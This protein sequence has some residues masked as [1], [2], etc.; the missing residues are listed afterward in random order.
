MK[1]ALELRTACVLLGTTLLVLGCGDGGNPTLA[2]AAPVSD[3]ADNGRSLPPVVDADVSSG[4]SEAGARKDVADATGSAADGLAAV[5][6]ALPPRITVTILTPTQGPAADGGIAAPTVVVKTDRLAPD[7][8]V[9]IESFSSDGVKDVLASVKASLVGVQSKGVAVS[10]TLNQTQYTIVPESNTKVY[11]FSDT[12][13]DL[14]TLSSDFYDLQITALTVGGTSATATTRI[15]VDGGPTITFLQPQAGAY[16][17]GSIVVTATVTDSQSGLAS[18]A[19]SIGQYQLAPGAITSKDSQYTA[20]LDFGSYNPP[21]DGDQIIS[22]EAKNR[23]GTASL[24]TRKF[25]IDNVGPV[26]SATK[27]ATGDLIGKIITIEAKVADQAGVMTSSVVAVVAHGDTHFEVNLV[28]GSDGTYRQIFDTTQLPTYAIFPSISFRAQD[29]LGNQSSVG[30]LVSLDNTPP[31]MDLDPPDQFQL[32]R[33]NGE[34][35]WPFDPVGPDAIDDGSVVTQLFDLRARIE[36][37]GNDALTGTPDFVPISAVDPASV[38]VLILDDTSLPLVV[39]TSDP[40]DGICDDINPQ[41]VPSIDPQTSKDAQLLDM[42]PLP[43]YT[44]AGNFTYRPGSL[45]SGSD[46]SEPQPFCATA[47]SSLKNES[48]TYVLG[49]SSSLLSAIWTV[50]PIVADGLQCAGRQF[51]ASNNLHDGWACVAV[52]ASDKLGN[53]QVSRPIRICVA[54]KPDSTACSPTAM[55]GADINSI[56]LPASSTESLFVTTKSPVLG[57]GGAAIKDGDVLIFSNVSPSAVAAVN[58]SHVVNPQGTTGT[59]F[60]ITDSFTTPVLL[61]LD[62]LDKTPP[63]LKGTVGLVVQDGA[64]VRVVTTAATAVDPA[65]AGHAIL[66][67]G[68]VAPAAGESGWTINSADATGFK[69]TNSTVKL[70]G[71]AIPVS[72][73]PNC[74]GT[75]IKQSSGA[76]T[77]IDGT[78]PCK[79]WRSFPKYE[80]LQLK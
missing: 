21:L 16:V 57:V 76:T 5:D 70:G 4:T 31:I 30:Y 61:Y 28:K 38:K 78:K 20:T 23:N 49:Y 53:K 75:A 74:T 42:V 64:E 27:P 39:D 6:A 36:D 22:V 43:A 19:F 37:Q 29:L 34:C 44:G 58:G 2:P 68:G 35:S 77:Q 10:T 15:F 59:V 47:Y 7:V 73:L 72:N 67:K 56:S 46:G 48:L 54:A 25:T 80:T 12:P 40:P 71:G 13:L 60:A 50:A 63:V 41:L 33:K 55:G 14:S 24:A 17:K 62:N 26:I 52:E 51:D 79:P 8:R 1:R 66:W 32:L 45:C 9:E 3:G 11:S 69:L 65:F 18:V